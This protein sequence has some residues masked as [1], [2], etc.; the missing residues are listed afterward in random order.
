MRSAFQ[1]V[2]L[3]AGFAA[4]NSPEDLEPEMLRSEAFTAYELPIHDYEVTRGIVAERS[5]L[6]EIMIAHGAAPDRLPEVV[7]AARGVFDVRRIRAGQP[8]L[9][10]STPGSESLRYFI[11]EENELGYVVFDFD[12]DISVYRG[13]K[14]ARLRQVEFVGTIETNLYDALAGSGSSATLALALADIFGRKIDFRDLRKGDRFKVIF[15]QQ[16]TG[17]DITGIGRITA[18]WMEHDG[19]EY[20]AFLHEKAHETIF[21]DEH[22]IGL[23]T[24]FL[25]APIKGGRISSNYTRRRFHPIQKRYKPHLGTDYAAPEGTEILAMAKGVVTEARKTRHN[26]NYVKLDHGNG[27]VTQYLHMSAI[28]DRI[29]PGSEIDRG[30]VI[31]Y[32]GE[33]GL[34]VGPHVCLRFWKDERQVDFRHH[35]HLGAEVGRMLTDAEQ[36]AWLLP[37]RA[38]LDRLG[39]DVRALARTELVAD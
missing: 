30:Q 34:A 20:Y 24:T 14:R 33:T 7:D 13:K 10:L 8:Y 16:V 31:G 39:E 5:F 29:E 35:R 26:G 4:A 37:L 25:R 9:A 18:A 3:L 17:N 12:E 21:L 19:E 27:Y 15:E 22:G 36:A 11:Y 32:V 6:A 2:W 23:Q 1:L 28:A 38:R